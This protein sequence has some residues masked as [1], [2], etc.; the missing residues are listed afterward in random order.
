VTAFV[1]LNPFLRSPRFRVLRTCSFVATGFSAFA[2]I[3][4]AV[5]IFPYEQLDKQAGLR[6]YYLEGAILLVGVAIYLV[7]AP[8][9]YTF[10]ASC[11]ELSN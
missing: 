6:Y 4:H 10:L 1:V 11:V 3:I 5:T 2:P 9:H 7:R 8:A